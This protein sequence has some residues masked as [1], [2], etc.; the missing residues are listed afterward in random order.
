MITFTLVPPGLKFPDPNGAAMAS[1]QD[2][3]KTMADREIQW[4]SNIVVTNANTIPKARPI[5]TQ[6]SFLL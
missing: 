3:P 4:V 1:N 6:D 5:N 2:Y